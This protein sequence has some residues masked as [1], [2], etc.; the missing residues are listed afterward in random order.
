MIP[1]DWTSL[2][3]YAVMLAIGFFASRLG[4]RMPSGPTPT[5]APDPSL[6]TPLPAN[7]QEL[8]RRLLGGA[9]NRTPTPIMAAPAESDT[10][11]AADALRLAHRIMDRHEAQASA[12]STGDA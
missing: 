7:L 3:T 9:V 5:P 4:I 8:L 1:L 2:I 6:P 11:L 12:P 10:A